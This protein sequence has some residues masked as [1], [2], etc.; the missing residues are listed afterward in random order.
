MMTARGLATYRAIQA[1]YQCYRVAQ[2]L[3]G[4]PNKS[5]L[6]IGPGMGR[7]AYYCWTAGFAIHHNG[8]TN[9]H[10]GAHVFWLPCLEQN[11]SGSKVTLWTH[12]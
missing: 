5:I 10:C 3:F 11:Q 8:Y 12:R 9:G 6:E 1:L 4:D 7:T 2:E